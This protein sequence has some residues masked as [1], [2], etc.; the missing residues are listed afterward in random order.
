MGGP[1]LRCEHL[2]PAGLLRRE[3]LLPA[4]LILRRGQPPPP[5][6]AHAA[7]RRCHP[8]RAPAGVPP[9]PPVQL[10]QARRITALG[11]NLGEHFLILFSLSFSDSISVFCK[12]CGRQNKVMVVVVA[13][14]LVLQLKHLRSTCPVLRPASSSDVT[15]SGRLDHGLGLQFMLSNF[16]SFSPFRFLFHVNVVAARKW[17]LSMSPL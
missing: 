4:G 14:A 1:V 12:C 11:S 10:A 16:W 2:R 8:V 6:Q 13:V 7:G 9:R 15:T 17:S 3:H 5:A